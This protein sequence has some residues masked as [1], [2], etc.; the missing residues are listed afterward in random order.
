MVQGKTA[1]GR[2]R[3]PQLAGR[4][5]LRLIHDGDFGMAD[6]E[7]GGVAEGQQ[8]KQRRHQHEKPHPGIAQQLPELFPQQGAQP[9]QTRPCRVHGNNP[10][11]LDLASVTRANTSAITS[12]A[13]IWVHNSSGVMPLRKMARD[14]AM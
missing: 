2:D 6:I 7:A 9:D 10:S 14:R 4:G 11:F 12:R 3:R 1:G 5:R 8:L 13:T